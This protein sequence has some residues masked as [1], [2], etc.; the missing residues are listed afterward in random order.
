MLS[1]THGSNGRRR[2][3]LTGPAILPNPN[4]R[5]RR[6]QYSAREHLARGTY[7]ADR[8]GPLE[9]AGTRFEPLSCR[10][11]PLPPRK[12]AQKW[13][14]SP[15]D[16]AAIKAG[17]RFDPAQGAYAIGWIAKH[18][19]LVEG[20]WTGQP[21]VLMP[22]QSDF[23]MRLLGWVKWSEEWGRWALRYR[24]ALVMVPKK[25]GKS[26]FAAAIGLLLAYGFHAPEQIEMGSEVVIVAKDKI[27]TDNVF[28]HVRRMV[29]RSSALAATCH[30]NESLARVLHGPTDTLCRALAHDPDQLEGLNPRALIADELHVWKGTRL[31]ESIRW[32]G[33]SRPDCL[34]LAISTAGDDRQSLLWNQY[35]YARDVNA[36]R[37]VDHEFLGVVYEADDDDDW[38]KPSVWKKANPSLGNTVKRSEIAAS[39]TEA[40]ANGRLQAAFRRYRLN[41]WTQPEAAWLD[42]Q[43]WKDCG[44][45]Y[46]LEQIEGKTCALG[47][48]LSRT[49]DLTAAVLT[50]MDDDCLCCWPEFWLPEETARRLQP[51]VP[52]LDW[53]KAKHLHLTPGDTVD[54]GLVFDRIRELSEQTYISHVLYDPWNAEH[55]TARFQDELGIERLKFPQTVS[56]FNSP[57]KELE[58]RILS[59][60]F[61][62][63][64]N[65]VLTWQAGHVLVY[66]DPNG[67]IRPV[68]REKTDHRTID[69]IVALIMATAQTIR[70]LPASDF[71]F[72]LD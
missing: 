19:Q 71:A 15:A 54:Y 48:D 5:G 9:A 56:N 43:Y 12:V 11:L 32:A 38:T 49:K 4:R 52:M 18:L 29:K 41:V 51:H 7:R 34:L 55:I 69:G 2:E 60:S 10:P 25:N 64:K 59:A 21:F 45:R 44:R 31:W 57:A 65:P 47:L 63:P 39:C 33:A 70:E 42:A 6:R 1:P 22:W 28:K 17:Y 58:R 30:I 26:P 50:W 16:L 68:R 24:R 62:H 53:A 37:I 27:Q 3:R 20:T 66:S 13:I 46:G 8:H 23:L 67:N 72:T 40:K 35:E 36:G 14:R 61:A